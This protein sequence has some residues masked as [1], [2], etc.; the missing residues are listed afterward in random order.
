MGT[1]CAYSDV[2]NGLDPGMKLCLLMI[3]YLDYNAMY[4]Y[5]WLSTFQKNLL[6]S[7]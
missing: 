4:Y 2:L 5:K 3:G 1:V 7:F 6:P